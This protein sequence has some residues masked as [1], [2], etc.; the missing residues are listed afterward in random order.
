MKKSLKRIDRGLSHY[1]DLKKDLE[2]EDERI[3]KSL[4]LFIRIMYYDTNPWIKQINRFD[5]LRLASLDE[6]FGQ[7]DSKI[8]NQVSYCSRINPRTK[9]YLEIPLNEFFESEILKIQDKLY[10]VKD[11]V[12]ALAYNGGIHMI[13]DKKFEESYNLIYEEFFE[14]F[15]IISF[16]I[17]EQISKILVQIFD[18]LYS[19]LVGD[20]NAYAFNS[21]FAPK[22]AEKGKI[23]EG[24]L[25]EHSYMQFPVREK[26]SKGI[27][28]CVEFKIRG[29]NSKNIIF[30]YGHR[31]IE[32]LRIK[33]FNSKTYVIVEVKTK[34]D[35]ETLRYDLKEKI[36][37]FINLEI[38]LY[39]SGHLILA[40][41]NLTVANGKVNDKI[42]IIDGKVIMGSNLSG[43]NFGEFFE[44][45]ITVQ[46]I[47]NN[48]EF[49][50]L[51]AYA[52]KKLS[53]Q[54]QNIPYNQIK[55]EFIN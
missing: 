46:S 32:D 10:T 29:N 19:I 36:S 23:L 16:E 42:S 37:E 27:R 22:I 54:P 44:R 33:L 2:S 51:N 52:M 24:S 20:N 7:I 6:D 21:K 17:T 18:E 49:R 11:F 38:S 39:P 50:V 35:Q 34:N 26:K 45:T 12:F 9:T 40:I 28:F 15:P 14:K 55:R 41:N 53:L 43:S 8:N 47:D 25:F 48:N 1:R 30:E 4:P 13:P 31:E 3:S 5:L